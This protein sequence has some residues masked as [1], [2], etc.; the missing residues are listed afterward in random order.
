MNDFLKLKMLAIVAIA[1]KAVKLKTDRLFV[2]K[3]E[4]EK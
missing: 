1:A 4:T 3:I 2:R